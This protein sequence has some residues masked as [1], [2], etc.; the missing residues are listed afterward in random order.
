MP[1]LTSRNKPQHT[2]KLGPLPCYL[3]PPEG[4]LDPEIF[5]DPIPPKNGTKPGDMKE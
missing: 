4:S 1:G 2:L 5:V 3:I